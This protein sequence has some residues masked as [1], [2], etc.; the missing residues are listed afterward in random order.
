[1]KHA[2]KIVISIF[3]TIKPRSLTHMVD[4]LHKKLPLHYV[5]VN[6]TVPLTQLQSSLTGQL[7]N[8]T[9]HYP[10]K[11]TFCPHNECPVKED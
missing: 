6:G 5:P 1:M 8:G 3:L 10:D 11:K 9:P 2:T 4:Y 7:V